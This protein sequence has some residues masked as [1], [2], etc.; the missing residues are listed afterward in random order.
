MNGPEL[1]E[2]LKRIH[3]VTTYQALADVYGVSKTTIFKIRDEQ[4]GL[5]AELAMQIAKN[6][7]TDPRNVLAWSK[8]WRSKNSETRKFWMATTATIVIVAGSYAVADNALAVNTLSNPFIH[9]AKL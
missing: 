4:Q 5:S 9:Y 3:N 6:L 8:A 1:V 7:D 2:S